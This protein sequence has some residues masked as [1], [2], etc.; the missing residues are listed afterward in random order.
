MLHLDKAPKLKGDCEESTLDA[1]IQC[2]AYFSDPDLIS[3]P[4]STKL[5][6]VV[7]YKHM[8]N[9]FDDFEAHVKASCGSASKLSAEYT[10]NFGWQIA[11]LRVFGSSLSFVEAFYGC[12]NPQSKK[13]FWTIDIGIPVAAMLGDD[14]GKNAANYLMHAARLTWQK[15][16]QVARNAVKSLVQSSLTKHDAIDHLV[17][18]LVQLDLYDDD[19]D[20]LNHNGV[21]VL[22]ESDQPAFQTFDQAVL[23]KVIKT[24]LLECSDDEG[25]T[26]KLKIISS[27]CQQQIATPAVI[28]S[29]S[30]TFSPRRTRSAGFADANDTKC[31]SIDDVKALAT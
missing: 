2:N 29:P 23:S 10:F 5:D 19:F 27:L 13:G 6:E 21:Q 3:C 30:A 28:S 17:K 18:L 26:K 4:L 11:C 15:T 16:D 25:A 8:I 20:A 14:F 1:I 12:I 31:Q 9:D 24:L 22:G 7:H